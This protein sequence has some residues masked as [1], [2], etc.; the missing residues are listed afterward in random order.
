MRILYLADVRFPIERANGIQTM[1][2]CHALASRGHVIELLVRPDTA[3]PPRDPFAFYDRPHDDRL[4]IRRARVAGREPVRRVAYIAQALTA[5]RAARRHT[6]IVMTR[7][8]GVASLLLRIPAGARPPLVYESHGYAPVFAETRPELLAGAAPASAAKLRRLAARETRVWRL[9]EGY[10]TISRGLA[11]DLS[12]RL[13][14]RPDVV[15]IPDGARIDPGRQYAPLHAE[16]ATRV[17]VY[18]G[19]L[20][21]ARGVDVLLEALARLPRTRAVIAG[22]HPAEAD[23]GRLR[24]LAATLGVA[25]RVTFTG[26]IPRKDVPALLADADVLV[27]PY[28][29]TPVIERYSSPLKLFE[30]MAAGKPI[31][32][33]DMASVREVLSDGVNARLV[34]PANADALAAGIA[35]LIEDRALADRLARKAFEDVQAYSWDRRA[36]HLEALFERVAAGR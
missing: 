24:E 22:G 36:E 23:L 5:T 34:P 29:S 19:H 9:A 13:G 7:D 32:A 35:N 6:D 16:R 17:I 27:M 28:F 15:V 8:L 14:P 33:S 20:Y 31:L 10:A 25:D 3:R 12:T 30:Y 11:E 18:V 2:T 26:M 4:I 21:R 1:E